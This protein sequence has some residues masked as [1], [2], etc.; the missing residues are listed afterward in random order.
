MRLW[1]LH[2]KYLDSKGLVALWREALLAQAVLRG[3]TRGYQNHPQLY[4]FKEHAASCSAIDT[5]LLSVLAEANSRGF[6]FD[7]NKVQTVEDRILINATVG[8]LKYEW[9][10]LLAKL[11]V[12]RPSLH[13]QW[14]RIKNPEAHPMFTIQR[15]AV[16][17]WEKK[18][19]D[20]SK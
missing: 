13:Q 15:G 1:T 11:K 4:R 12:R 20:G 6:K 14:N 10:H 9:Q 16:E 19:L 5:Y 7:R 17:S 8:Q 18:K 2:P 3:R